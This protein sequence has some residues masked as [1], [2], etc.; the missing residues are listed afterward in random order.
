MD[1]FSKYLYEENS[2]KSTRTPVTDRNK[3]PGCGTQLCATSI[4]FTM[5][6]VRERSVI[7]SSGATPAN[8]EGQITPR[9]PGPRI[10]SCGQC[11]LN[12]E[13]RLQPE[14]LLSHLVFA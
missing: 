11:Y 4:S 6:M 9:Y 13:S 5:Q 7:T 2:R 1:G 8:Q 12:P 10:P 14:S 3:A